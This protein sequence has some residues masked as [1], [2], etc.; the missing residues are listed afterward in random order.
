MK[1]I[2]ITVQILEKDTDAFGNIFDALGNKERKNRI[3]PLVLNKRRIP[4]RRTLS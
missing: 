4:V 2:D 1:A 3:K